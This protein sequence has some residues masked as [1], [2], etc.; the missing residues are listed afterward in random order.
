[1]LDTTAG[2]QQTG[3]VEGEGEGEGVQRLIRYSSMSVL[4]PVQWRF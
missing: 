1:M 3:E 4:I 2:M